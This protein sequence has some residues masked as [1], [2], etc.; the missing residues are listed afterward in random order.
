MIYGW[1]IEE[2]LRI[3]AVAVRGKRLIRLQTMTGS[4]SASEN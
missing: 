3:M 4:E 1:G 2:T